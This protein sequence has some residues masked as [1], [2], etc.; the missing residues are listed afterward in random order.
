MKCEQTQSNLMQLERKGRDGQSRIQAVVQR[1]W[2][3][4]DEKELGM[5]WSVRKLQ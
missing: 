1:I 5:L 2:S 4:A 3:G